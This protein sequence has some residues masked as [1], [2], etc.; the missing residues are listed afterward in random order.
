MPFPPLFF[1]GGSEPLIFGYIQ[2][3]NL[4]L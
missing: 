1:G 3:N 2:P 4:M